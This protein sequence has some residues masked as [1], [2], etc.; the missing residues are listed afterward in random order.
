MPEGRVLS[1]GVVSGR[2][3]WKADLGKILDYLEPIQQKLG[4]RLWIAPSCSLLHVP[5]DLKSE[6]KLIR[7]KD[8]TA[9]RLLQRYNVA[10]AQAVLLRSIKVTA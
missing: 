2:N 1:L 9:E 5:V 7:F 3:I 8:I 10:L 4:E 6:Q